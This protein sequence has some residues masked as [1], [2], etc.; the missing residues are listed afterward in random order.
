MYT[1]P[2][3][4]DGREWVFWQYSHKGRLN[5][6]SGKEKFIDL[7]VFNGSKEYFNEL[8]LPLSNR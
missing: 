7:N 1:K 5:G 6:Y 2:V 4:S 3:L 8:F